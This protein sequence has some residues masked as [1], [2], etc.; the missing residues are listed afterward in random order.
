MIKIFFFEVGF[1]SEFW[2]RCN[3]RYENRIY[4][5]RVLWVV[6]IASEYYYIVL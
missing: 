5:Q 6:E 1:E 4:V 3:T 2:I